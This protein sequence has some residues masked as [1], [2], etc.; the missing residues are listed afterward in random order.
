MIP[1]FRNNN[2]NSSPM[3]I[4][5]S[6]VDLIHMPCWLPGLRILGN[7]CLKWESS[8]LRVLEVESE[9]FS[10]QGEAKNWEF[11]PDAVLCQGWDVS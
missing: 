8:E 6:F 2:N 11:S 3:F 4:F 7:L 9:C 10:A 5:Y 1:F